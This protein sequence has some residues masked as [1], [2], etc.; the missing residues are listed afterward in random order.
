MSLITHK[1]IHYKTLK[2]NKQQ[3]ERSRSDPPKKQK[4]GRSPL[5]AEIQM[6]FPIIA[7][8]HM[9]SDNGF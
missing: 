3:Y 1:N 2:T 7:H 8:Y 4:I 6:P 5:W 9:T